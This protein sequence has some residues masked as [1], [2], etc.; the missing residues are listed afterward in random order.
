ME[1]I[2]RNLFTGQFFFQRHFAVGHQH[3]KFRTC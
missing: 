3:R 1:F 2:L